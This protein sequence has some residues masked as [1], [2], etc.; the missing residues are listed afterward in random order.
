M[1]AVIVDDE[2][3]AR[4]QLRALL[5]RHENIDVVGEADSVDSA[6][7]AIDKLRPDVVF[8]DIQMPGRDGFE[9]LDRIAGSVIFVTAYDQFAVRA[10]E[11]RA[12]D[13][14]LKPVSAARLAQALERLDSKA[15]FVFIDQ[16]VVKL[17]TI[18][19]IRAAGAYSEVFTADGRSTL[20][21]RGMKSWQLRLP[22]DR[23]VRVHRS[24][25][26]NLQHV[27]RIA[28][29]REIVLRSG[30]LI[31]ISR[32]QDKRLKGMLA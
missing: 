8:L 14:L 7:A 16:R 5:A 20:A 19:W 18:Q 17:D 30:V 4:T 6:A 29:T 25:I 11:A 31:P 21:G 27:E 9:L 13:Y 15:E 3:L 23:F 22:R 12:L 2:R 24:A 26:V 1:R 32:R 28:E 10:F